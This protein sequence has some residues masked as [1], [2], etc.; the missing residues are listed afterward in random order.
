MIVV[1][2]SAGGF[3]ALRELLGQLPASIP[4]AVFVV[5]HIAPHFSGEEFVANLQAETELRCALATHAELFR[6]GHVYVAPPDV[7]LLLKGKRMIVTKGAH[8][9][10]Y[11][12]AIDPLFRSAAV[13]LGSRVI[14]VLLT[15]MLDDGTAGMDAIQRCG[16]V[17]VVQDP[18]DAA[19]PAMPQSALDNVRI[20]HRVALAGMGALLERIVREKPPPRVAAPKDLL[21]E[22]VIAERVVSDVSGT[23]ALG[24][25]VPYNCP[26]CGGVLWE[27]SK[28]KLL[29]Y[30]CHTGH[31]F[32]AHALLATQQEKIEETLWVMLRMLE[33]RRNLAHAL[34][35]KT[36]TRAGSSSARERAKEADV[37]IARLRE[38]LGAGASG[39]RR[40]E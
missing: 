27:M 38:M 17:T 18:A 12:P 29:R 31:A 40:G 20:S 1:G 8:E 16:G 19:F 26:D 34:A 21:M 23:E 24:E 33:E 15:G 2:A 36:H 9:N 30:R 28:P 7:H 6:P 14:G 4:A 3:Q 35:A 25:Q 11:R 39:A 5:L 10:R 13:S 37:H 32:T 22:A